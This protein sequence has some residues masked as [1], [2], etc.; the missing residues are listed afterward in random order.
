MKR[1]SVALLCALALVAC[2]TPDRK[3]ELG[4]KRV[5]LSL[6][7][8]EQELAEPVAPRVLYQLVPAPPG[9]I[10]SAPITP[11]AQIDFELPAY[12]TCPA[13]PDGAVAPVAAKRVAVAPPPAGTYPRRNTGTVTLE[14]GV[15]PINLPFPPFSL[16]EYGTPTPTEVTPSAVAGTATQVPAE[17]M[18][19]D[20]YDVVKTLT[21]EFTIT[22]RLRRTPNG[23]EMLKRT[24]R[25]NGVETVFTPEPPII[26]HQFQVEG[27]RWVSS[28]VDRET[29]AAMLFEATIQSRELVDVCGTMV[30]TY[31]VT[32][33]EQLVNLD[34][35]EVSGS[36]PGDASTYNIAP[37]FGGLIVREDVHSTFQTHDPNTGTPIVVRFD[38][39]STTSTMEPV[40]L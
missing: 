26:I 22:E 21:P 5:A 6:A 20:E 25:A 37:H 10:E 16:W 40:V 8:A 28:G 11:P 38:Y 34:T 31:R 35:G 15:I 33:T 29:S 17:P 30:D 19:A 14:G 1:S 27:E 32:F 18:P 36:Q 12:L 23:I 13:A 39:V 9:L 7:F 24:T 3:V 2:S 4:V